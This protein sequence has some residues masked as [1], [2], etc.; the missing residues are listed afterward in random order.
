MASKKAIKKTKR[1]QALE[2]IKPL[3]KIKVSYNP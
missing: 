1:A 2:H 3:S